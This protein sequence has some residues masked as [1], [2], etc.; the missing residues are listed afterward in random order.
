VF[1]GRTCA[2]RPTLPATTRY[3][4]YAETAFYADSANHNDHKAIK[5]TPDPGYYPANVAGLTSA[6]FLNIHCV[7]ALERYYVQNGGG[8]NVASVCVT[9][10]GSK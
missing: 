4:E 5:T 6:I 9:Q 2:G 10:I 1:V 8:N 7:T 3:D